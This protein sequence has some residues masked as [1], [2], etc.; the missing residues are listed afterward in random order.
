MNRMLGKETGGF[1]MKGRICI[2]KW[3]LKGEKLDTHGV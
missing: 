2:I 3:S 1:G